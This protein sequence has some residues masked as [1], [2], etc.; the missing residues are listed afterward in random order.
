MI[1]TNLFELYCQTPVL[2]R[3]LVV[4]FTFTWDNKNKNNDNDDHNDNDNPHQ[5]FSRGTVIGVK[6]QGLGIRDKR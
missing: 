1:D 4:D 6:E 5:N 3:G 2:G